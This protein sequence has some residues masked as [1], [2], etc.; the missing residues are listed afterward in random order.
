MY[1]SQFNKRVFLS[2]CLTLTITLVVSGPGVCAKPKKKT[3]MLETELQAELMASADRLASYLHQA[4]REFEQSPGKNAQRPLVQRDVVLT[5]VSAF[6]IAA[7][8]DPGTAMLDMVAMVTMGR[9]I[10]EQ[11]WLPRHGDKFLPMVRALSKAEGEIWEL[12]AKIF[13]SSQQ[14]TLR[15]LITQ[16]R[17][18]NPDHTGFAYLRFD[19]MAADKS[20]SASDR[21]KASGLFKSVEIATQQV[22]ETRLMAERTTY[23]ATR[24]PLLAGGLGDFWMSELVRNQDIKMLLEDI[25]RLSSTV[26]QLPKIIAQ[27][28]SAAIDQSIQEIS[29]WSRTSI[30]QTMVGIAA[31]REQALKQFFGEFSKERQVALED[32]L[33][34]EKTY[35]RLMAEMRETLQSGNQLI[36]SANDLVNSLPVP[37]EAATPSGAKEAA[38]PM[39]IENYQTLLADVN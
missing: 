1:S 35:S 7:D 4:L 14:D 6:T 23:L 5:S 19:Y 37:D 11:H 28:R 2:F 9:L 15:E 25:H 33:A 18:D 36:L 16:W 26:D 24:I 38:P 39:T 21:K 10:Y 34:Q 20:A 13:E 29:A 8:P 17:D 30:E 12:A 31:E 27:E 32:L 3:R 22:E